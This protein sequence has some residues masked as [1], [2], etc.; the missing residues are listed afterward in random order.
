LREVG[1]GKTPVE[2]LEPILNY[3]DFSAVHLNLLSNTDIR[4]ILDSKTATVFCPRASMYFNAE[5]YFGPHRYRDL[6]F[7]GL[8]VALGTD[9]II[10]LWREGMDPAEDPSQMS[11]AAPTLS[12]LDEMRLLYRRDGVTA[13]GVLG[14]GTMDGASVLGLDP[15]SFT[16]KRNAQLAGVVA[17]SAQRPGIS[18][19]DLALDRILLGNSAPDLLLVGK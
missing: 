12:I 1:H 10:N 5:E 2:H 3:G 19:L 16:F 9:S 4:I 17:I 15:L 13:M 11:L 6:L 18:Q 8:K 14:L 7:C